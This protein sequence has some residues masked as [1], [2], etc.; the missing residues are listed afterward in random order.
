MATDLVPRLADDERLKREQKE[1]HASISP[2]ADIPQAD[3]PPAEDT[4]VPGQQELA[5]EPG[6]RV[7]EGAITAAVR[8][9]AADKGQQTATEGIVECAEVAIVPAPFVTNMADAPEDS[10]PQLSVSQGSEITVPELSWEEVEHHASIL[11]FADL[12]RHCVS[13]AGQAATAYGAGMGKLEQAKCIIGANIPYFQRLENELSDQGRRERVEGVDTWQEFLV[14]CFSWCSLATAKRAIKAIKEEYEQSQPKEQALRPKGAGLTKHDRQR[15]LKAAQIGGKLAE[16]HKD[17]PE[18][19]EYLSIANQAAPL[20]GTDPEASSQ[21]T[22]EVLAASLDSIAVF[23]ADLYRP[24]CGSANVHENI[25]VLKGLAENALKAMGKN[26][27]VT[28]V[29]RELLQSSRAKSEHKNTSV[30]E[31]MPL[32]PVDAAE[33]IENDGSRAGATAEH[34]GGSLEHPQPLH[35]GKTIDPATATS[36][37]GVFKAAPARKIKS[38][39]TTAPE[40]VT[41]TTKKRH[42]G[43]DGARKPAKSIIADGTTIRA[44]F[45][46]KHNGVDCQ[47]TAV[48]DG[49]DPV[50]SLVRLDDGTPVGP[51]PIPA[52]ELRFVTDPEKVAS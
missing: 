50:V 7:N 26:Y 35:P 46:C 52:T 14:K 42:S 31:E 16:K 21:P 34:A 43:T 9:P 39:A 33:G 45:N 24:G 48:F 10:Q 23:I 17:E 40:L 11:P 36:T 28:P 44:G 27:A 32:G 12:F 29:P 6:A 41:P 5:P 15:L 3:S 51:G 30:V 4:G 49:V 25:G 37:E 1:H 8:E 13:I 22:Y 2:P 20:F 18:A 19:M 47:I 38:R